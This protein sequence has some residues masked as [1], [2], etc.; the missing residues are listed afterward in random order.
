MSEKKVE[1]KAVDHKKS[2]SI[3]HWGQLLSWMETLVGTIQELPCAT[4]TTVHLHTLMNDKQEV[5]ARYPSV[6]GQFRQLISVDFDESYLLESR[7]EN[8]ITHFKER[9]MFEAKSRVFS[10]KMVRNKTLEDLAQAYLA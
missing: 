5:I 6:N 1:E 7:G 3:P 2:M 8:H 9:D 4:A 10:P